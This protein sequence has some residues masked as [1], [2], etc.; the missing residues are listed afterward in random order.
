MRVTGLDQIIGNLGGIVQDFPNTKREILREGAEFFYNDAMANVHE[1]TGKTK[2][3]IK[4]EHVSDRDAVISAG[5]GAKYEERRAGTK[6]PPRIGKGTGPHK[7]FTFA[8][9][10]TKAKM[11]EII[12]NHLSRLFAKHRSFF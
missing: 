1:I 8:G 9:I 10:R 2:Q 5:Y 3:S 12:M 7:F 11:P 6:P 4:I